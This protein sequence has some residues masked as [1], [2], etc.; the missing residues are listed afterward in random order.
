MKLASR[1]KVPPGLF[2]Y[3]HGI[4]GAEFIR[5]AWSLMRDDVTAHCEAN[6]YPPVSDDEIE[7]QMCE[8]LGKTIAEQYCEGDGLSV[9]GVGLHWKEIWEGTK[10]IGS[11]ILAG[12]PL[13]PQ[14]KAEWRA[15]LCATCER[16]VDYSKPCGGD[17][18]DLRETVNAI[19]GGG[20]TTY[21]NKLYGCSVCGCSN[22]AQVWVPI[23]QL[24]LGVTPEM[25]PQFTPQCWKRAELLEIQSKK[26]LQTH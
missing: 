26:E 10:V 2:R 19:V 8:R 16:N 25:L 12:R 3:K 18:P 1:S 20:K 21:D 9:K 13:V 14:E 23:E 17:C 4:S 5:H 6:G 11:F 24:K 15:S 22:K 7:A